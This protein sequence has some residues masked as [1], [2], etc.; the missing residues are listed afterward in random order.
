MEDVSNTVEKYLSINWKDKKVFMQDR[1][2]YPIRISATDEEESK[3]EQ[4]AALTEPLQMK[5]VF[6]DNKKMLYKSKSC[7]GVSFRWKRKNVVGGQNQY[8]SVRIT[9]S[10]KGECVS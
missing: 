9:I 10:S 7:D 5:A 3:V 4:T 2:A 8:F 1:D 6:F